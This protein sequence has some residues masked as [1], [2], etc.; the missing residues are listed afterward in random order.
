M[1][2]LKVEKSD[3]LTLEEEEARDLLYV[4]MNITGSPCKSIL[5]SLRDHYGDL[6]GDEKSQ[7]D[8]LMWNEE[9]I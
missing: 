1:P 5:A 2:K 3:H 4:L 9:E 7:Y 6:L 8:G